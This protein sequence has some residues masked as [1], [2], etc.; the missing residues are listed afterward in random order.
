[1]SRRI[2]AAFLVLSLFAGVASA[3]DSSTRSAGVVAGG[4]VGAVVT[5]GSG[6]LLPALGIAVPGLAIGAA[7]GSAFGYLISDRD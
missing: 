6:L 3:A 2:L 7:L 4:T 5:W 1:M